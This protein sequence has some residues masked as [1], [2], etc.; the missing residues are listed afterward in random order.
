MQ[1]WCSDK[2]TLRNSGAVSGGVSCGGWWCSEDPALK[3]LALC[4][5][6]IQLLP[7]PAIGPWYLST[8]LSFQMLP[9]FAEVQIKILELKTKSLSKPSS[10]EG[11]RQFSHLALP[12]L[13]TGATYILII[14][15]F[16]CFSPLCYWSDR[17]HKYN[18][19]LGLRT[20]NTR[21]YLGKA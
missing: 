16:V 5:S 4:T 18:N 14:C 1:W 9:C 12:P 19:K 10:C 6:A 20:K 21:H 8:P 2:L 11:F 15:L 17:R 7:A 13:V 3:H